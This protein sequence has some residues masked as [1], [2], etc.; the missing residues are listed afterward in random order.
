MQETTQ[1]VHTILKLLH[2]SSSI[3]ESNGFQ[4]KTHKYCLDTIFIHTLLRI[5]KGQEDRK[6]FR[7]KMNTMKQ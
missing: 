2:I 1:S 6:T 4:Q 7:R 5:N 3:Q